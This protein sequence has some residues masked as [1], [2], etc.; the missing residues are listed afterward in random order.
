MDTVDAMIEHANTTS[1]VVNLLEVI[2]KELV[3]VDRRLTRLE[4][5]Q[6]MVEKG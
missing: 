5:K 6:N 1:K 2:Y 3:K 4:K